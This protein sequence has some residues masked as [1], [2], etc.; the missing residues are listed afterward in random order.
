MSSTD[1]PQTSGQSNW[2]K[3]HDGALGEGKRAHVCVEVWRMARMS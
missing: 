2:V 3:V 1:Q